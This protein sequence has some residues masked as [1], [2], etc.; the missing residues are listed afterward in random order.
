MKRSKKT[1]RISFFAYLF[2]PHF[3][4][5]ISAAI[6]AAVLQSPAFFSS[7]T[8]QEDETDCR[9]KAQIYIQWSE[10]PT[11]DALDLFFFDQEGAMRLDAYQQIDILSAP[12]GVYALS[13]SG[14]RHLVAISNSG[15]DIYDWAGIQTYGSLGKLRFSLE[16][17]N[18]ERP[19]LVGEAD[20]GEGQSH[21]LFLQL[22]PMLCAIRI[23]SVACDFSG[24]PYAGQPFLFNKLYLIHA[25]TECLPLG[26]EGCGPVSWMNPGRA[27]STAVSTLPHPEMLLQEGCGPVSHTRA[28]PDRVLYCYAN[29]VMED[30]PGMPVTRV[31]LEGS[32]AGHTCYY[33]VNLPGMVPG[34]YFILDLTLTRMGSPDPDIPVESGTVILET[35]IAP[36]QHREPETLTV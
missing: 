2:C 25:G 16:E 22:R 6:L 12:G 27:D 5:R 4:G 15:K 30:E 1:G 17:E 9:T 26:G 11:P 24:H 19:R 28:Y 18:P 31:I 21:N 23:R 34:S 36:W 32:V 7:C 3:A 20:L 13:G 8:R 33:P 29:P 10:N 14:E 35:E